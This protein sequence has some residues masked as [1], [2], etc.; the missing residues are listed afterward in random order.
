MKNI[1][2]RVTCNGIG[3]YEA[4]KNEI[5][6]SSNQPKK[7]WETFI[8]S[9]DVNWLKK[10]DG[11]K[12]SNYSY[13]TELGYSLFK[14]KTYPKII[15]WLDKNNIKCE[16]CYLNEMDTYFAYSDEHQ[17]VILKNSK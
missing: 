16:K 10:P 14:E 8:N 5:W 17:V 4:L 13:F 9:S 15:K 1:Y 3:V 11:Y 7:D 6:K 2:Y 12:S